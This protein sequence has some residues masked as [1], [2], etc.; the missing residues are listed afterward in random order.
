MKHV[1]TTVVGALALYTTSPSGLAAPAPDDAVRQE[2]VRFGDLDLTR[3]ADAQELYRRIRN[4]AHKVCESISD[5]ASR[6]G[7]QPSVAHGALHGADTLADSAGAAGETQSL[8][9]CCG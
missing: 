8:N 3:A 4:A 2:I 5:L 6:R 9:R 7:P 1:I